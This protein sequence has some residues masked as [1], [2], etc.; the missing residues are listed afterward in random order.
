MLEELPLRCFLL[1]FTMVYLLFDIENFTR[2]AE[3]A[4]QFV[5]ASDVDAR[6]FFF[7]LGSLGCYECQICSRPRRDSISGYFFVYRHILPPLEVLCKKKLLIFRNL[8]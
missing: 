2:K 4:A 7:V 8:C 3:N 5:L 6:V 1:Q